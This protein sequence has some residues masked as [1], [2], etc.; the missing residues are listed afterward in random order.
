MTITRAP[1]PALVAGAVVL[2][3]ALSSLVVLGPHASADDSGES[4]LQHAGRVAAHDTFAGLVEVRWIDDRGHLHAERV[5]ARSLNGAFTI[6]RGEHHMVGRGT[7]RWTNEAGV[8]R[9]DSNGKRGTQPPPPGAHWDLSVTGHDTVGDRPATVVVARD[10]KGRV[11]ARFAVDRERGQL[12]ER[13]VL[14]THG[15][16]VRSVSFV[17][18]ATNGVGPTLP[19]LPSGAADNDAPV[20][21]RDAP[22]GFLAPEAVGNGYQL[23]GRYL[24]PDGMLQLYYGDGLFSLSVFEQQGHVDWAGLP[25]GRATKVAGVRTRQYWTAAGTV[26]V[27]GDER[28]VLT[29]VG[30][31]PPGALEAVIA[32]ISGAD[33]GRGWVDDVA[34]YVLGPFGWE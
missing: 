11:R 4:L 29:A 25:E 16:V 34:N 21:I 31:G 17:T 24:H 22:N 2:T 15:N 28:L 6:G 20:V 9:S 27:W 18:I 8:L 32:D 33:N 13:D 1:R 30:D 12:L 19:E 23:L 26:C 10:R 5:V 14:D 3:L 7:Q